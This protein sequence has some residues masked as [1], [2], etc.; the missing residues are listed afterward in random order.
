MNSLSN[1]ASIQYFR[2]ELILCVAMMLVI[3]ADLATRG[4]GRALN[5]ILTV[6]ALA[7][8]RRVDSRSGAL[9]R[10]RR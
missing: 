6:G 7:A 8:E 4:R 3:I 2:P 1:L 5:A 10:V 9:G